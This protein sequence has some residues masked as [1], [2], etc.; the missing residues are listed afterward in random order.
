MNGLLSRY[1][2]T[3]VTGEVTGT[4]FKKP[5]ENKAGNRGNTGNTHLRTHT[6]NTKPRIAFFS[7][8]PA[9]THMYLLPVLPVLPALIHNAF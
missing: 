9:Y 5:F 2:V 4:C 1:E 7:H 6:R 3:G 8:P